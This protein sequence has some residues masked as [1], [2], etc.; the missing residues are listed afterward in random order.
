MTIPRLT[1]LLSDPASAGL[2]SDGLLDQA[3]KTRLRQAPGLSQRLDWQVSRVLKFRS[4]SNTQSLSHSHGYAALLSADMPLPIGV[5]IEKIK[6]RDFKAL[7]AWVCSEQ[8]RHYLAETDWQAEEFY[9]LWCI[10]EAL[11][12]SAGL[13]FPADMARVGYLFRQNRIIGLSVEGQ[14]RWHGLS[15]LLGHEFAIAC[16]WY[17]NQSAEIDWRF[18][19]NLNRQALSN[20]QAV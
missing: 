16:V 6:P 14:K 19:G 7:A 9:R 15:A 3:D 11:I 17:G 12:K 4:V 13:N 10:K 5:D 18:Y 20:R 8:E 2:Y 1:C